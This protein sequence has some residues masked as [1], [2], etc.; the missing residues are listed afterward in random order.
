MKASTAVCIFQ[1]TLRM[2]GRKNSPKFAYASA[3]K[4]YV[5][6]TTAQSPCERQLKQM[7]QS[8][9]AYAAGNKYH[10]LIIIYTVK[11]KQ[12]FKI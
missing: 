2:S 6:K 11:K 10:Q 7:V 9:Y 3:K 5:I 1:S 8:K 12:Y 4:C